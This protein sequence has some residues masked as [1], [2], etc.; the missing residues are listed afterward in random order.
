M[1]IVVLLSSSSS[2]TV[3]AGHTVTV[4]GSGPYMAKD[5]TVALN[6]KLFCN[7]LRVEPGRKP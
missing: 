3:R 4:N 7:Q 1:I 5:L 6:G 2:V